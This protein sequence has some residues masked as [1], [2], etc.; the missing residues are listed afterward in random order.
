MPLLGPGAPIRRNEL[1]RTISED[2]SDI[3][4]AGPTKH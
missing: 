1:G 3:E 2:S 4:C